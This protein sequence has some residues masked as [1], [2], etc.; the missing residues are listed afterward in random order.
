MKT[1][2]HMPMV[3]ALTERELEI[4]NLISGGL[5][6]RQIADQLVLSHGTVKWYNKQIYRKLGVHSRTHAVAQ[7]KKAGLFDSEPEPPTRTDKVPVHNLPAQVTSFIGR[8]HE[9]QEIKDLLRTVR[10]LTLTGPGGSG[11]TRLALLTASDVL[12]RFKDGVFFVNLAPIRDTNLLLST[13]IRALGLREVPGQSLIESLK[14]NLHEKQLLLLLDNFEQIIEAAPQVAELLSSSP[15][16]RV[17][18]TSREALQIYGEQEYPVHPLSIP[19]LSRPESSQVLSQYESTELFYQR[20]KAVKPD[21]MI[22]P[23]NGPSIA[24]ICVRLDGLPLAIEL[25]A[26]RSKF[27]SPEMIRSRLSNRLTTLSSGSRDVPARLQTLRGTLDWSYDL[28]DIGEQKLFERLSVFQG[29]RTVE[30]TDAVCGPGLEIDVLDGLESLLN[31]NLLY[32]EQDSAGEPR[33]YLLE[34]VH[35]YGCEKLEESG[36]VEVLKRRHAEYF[37]NLAAQAENELFR[38]GQANWIERLRTEQDNLRAALN[39]SLDCAEGLEVDRKGY[40][41]RRR[42]PKKHS[43]QSD[44]Y[45]RPSIFCS[46]RL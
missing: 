23:E 15:G 4:I 13:I 20:A 46:G 1:D 31:K 16:L 29:G 43:S 32:Q 10:L 12:E 33:F 30:S 8:A 42:P 18:V 45:G 28:L 39:W 17:L 34:T 9:I 3:E 44:Q 7:A 27:Y 19:D 38:D 41:V 22:T 6:N 24:E 21:F 14:R 5:S 37:A 40:C 11:K 35:E 26:A 36:E 2:S 25:A